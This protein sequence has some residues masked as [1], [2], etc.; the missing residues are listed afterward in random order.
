MWVRLEASD[1]GLQ[2]RFVWLWLWG[3]QVQRIP[4][5]WRSWSLYL[6]EQSR[7]RASRVPNSKSRAE[8]AS[9]QTAGRSYMRLDSFWR[10]WFVV[11]W[12]CVFLFFSSSFSFFQSGEGERDENMMCWWIWVSS[13]FSP[14][15]F[16]SFSL[17]SPIH[18][19][20]DGWKFKLEEEE[21]KGEGRRKGGG[22]VLYRYI[23][24]SWVSGGEQS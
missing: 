24:Q 12:T 22:D 20:S 7:A 3:W 4:K 8:V 18:K 21:W 9:I 2:V 10:D 15:F 13:F 19:V 23:C 11:N 1:G 6:T 5:M 16:L 17:R 14:F